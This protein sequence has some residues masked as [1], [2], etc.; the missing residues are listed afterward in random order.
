MKWWIYNIIISFLIFAFAFAIAEA[1]IAEDDSFGLL[2]SW[3]S[4]DGKI[5]SGSE[6][7]IA[8]E[9]ASTLHK[10]LPIYL[11][12]NVNPRASLGDVSILD[13]VNIHVVDL[14][15]ESGLYEQYAR[16]AAR[17]IKLA[18]RISC[19]TKIQSLLTGWER[20]ILPRRVIHMDL[21]VV[22][23]QR[24]SLYSMLEPLSH[25]DITGIKVVFL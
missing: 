15:A 1:P 22:V 4:F 14:M 2:F 9:S 3:H 19:A 10:D 21:D 13:S 18:L 16:V 7:L 17:D 23:L 12:S 5:G 11:M 8:L 20:G 6:L 24:D 25:Y